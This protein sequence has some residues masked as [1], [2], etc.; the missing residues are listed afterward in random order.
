[1]N[2]FRSPGLK[3]KV[4]PF[5]TA[6]MSLS[7][8]SSAP[9]CAAIA[10]A[11]SAALSLTATAANAGPCTMEIAQ[12][13]RQISA[14]PPGPQTGPTGTQTVAAQL[15]HQPTP[16]TVEHAEH[17]ANAEADSAL[18]RARKADADNNADACSQALR[19][20]RRLYGLD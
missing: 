13:E 15:H 19:E 1:M 5:R 11:L 9:Q 17:R 3:Q 7:P 12:L 2:I 14:E 18:D 8:C 10:L 16:G 6:D 4:H 20:A